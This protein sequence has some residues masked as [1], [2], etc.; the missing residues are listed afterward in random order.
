MRGLKEIIVVKGSGIGSTELSAF[1]A[2]LRD[3]GIHDH[4]LITLSSIIPPGV[5]VREGVFS[6]KKKLMGGR[7]YVVLS[8]AFSNKPGVSAVAAIGWLRPES[9]KSDSCGIFMESAGNSERKV[10]DDVRSSLLSVRATRFP[11][12][13]DVTIEGGLCTCSQ[14]CSGKGTVACA[15]V[16]AVYKESGWAGI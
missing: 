5:S 11:K 16:A 4:N 2:A 13:T 12:S 14:E 6:G 8:R 9:R 3:A 10:V 15:V 1:D 7:L